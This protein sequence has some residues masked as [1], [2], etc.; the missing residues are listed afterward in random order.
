[1]KN[2]TIFLI[3]ILFN[4]FYYHVFSLDLYVS[5]TGNDTNT[6]AIDNPLQTFDGA[7]KR[8]R[9][10]IGGGISEDI[11]VF[12]REGM[13]YIDTPIEFTEPDSNPTGNRVTYENYGEDDVFIAGGLKIT[14][15]NNYDGMIWSTNVGF[16]D[17]S[18]F[19][20]NRD[21]GIA[22]LNPGSLSLNEMIFKLDCPGKYYY[23]GDT[24]ILYYYPRNN[25]VSNQCIFFPET[26]TIIKLKGSSGSSPVE[27]ISFH[28]LIIVGTR[29][30]S[31]GITSFYDETGLIHMENAENIT[32]DSC[33]LIGAGVSGI[34]VDKYARNIK[35]RNN[36]I[37]DFNFHGVS[38]RGY[39]SGEGPSDA[40][41]NN[42]LS[43]NFIISGAY[44]SSSGS[45]I[46]I[47]QSR[48]NIIEKNRIRYI[49]GNGIIINGPDASYNLVRNN[50]VSRVT[51]VTQGGGIYLFQAGSNNSISNNC[52]HDIYI[53]NSALIP[54][55]IYVGESTSNALIENN[56][57]HTM[58]GSNSKGRA[59]FLSG[60]NC[61]IKN[62]IFSNYGTYGGLGFDASS[63]HARNPEITQNIF[64]KKNG[65]YF[66]VFDEWNNPNFRESNNN[67][68]YHSGS[69]Y[70]VKTPT[71][72][73]DISD[74]RK[75]Y[76]I[77]YDRQSII[78]EDPEFEEPESHYYKVKTGSPVLDL[79]FTNINQD[80]IGIESSFAHRYARDAIEAEDYNTALGIANRVTTIRSSSSGNYTRYGSV[81]FDSSLKKVEIKLSCNASFG[82]GTDREIEIRAQNKYGSLSLCTIPINGTGGITSYIIDK[83]SIETVAGLYDVYLRF[84]GS[85]CPVQVDW[86]RFYAQIPKE[87]DTGINL[88]PHIVFETPRNNQEFPINSNITITAR[89]EDSDGSVVKMWLYANEKLLYE[90][91]DS[92]FSFNWQ[93]VPEGSYLLK[94]VAEDNDSSRDEE[95]V[96]IYVKNILSNPPDVQILEPSE[97]QKF[98]GPCNIDIRVTAEDLSSGI[99]FIEIRANNQHL[100]TVPANS[101]EYTWENVQP[102]DYLITAIA[103]NNAG[104]KQ[105]TAVFIWVTAEN[106]L[107]GHWPMDSVVGG[108]VQD[109][110]GKEHHGTP[111]NAGEIY[112]VKGGGALYF[113]GTAYITTNIPL[114]NVLSQFTMAGWIKPEEG[115]TKVGFFGQAGVVSLG[116]SNDLIL[117]V[118]TIGKGGIEVKYPGQLNTWHHL[119]V[120][121]NQSGMRLYFDGSLI[122]N[123]TQAVSD[124]G[125]SDSPF[126]SGGGIFSPGDTN[127]TGAIDDVRLYSYAIGETELK[128]IASKGEN[129]RPTVEILN[130]PANS[131]YDGPLDISIIVNATDLDGFVESVEVYTQEYHI[132]MAYEPPYEFIWAG[133]TPGTHLLTVKAIDNEYDENSKT[134]MVNVL[135]AQSD[136]L[137]YWDF[138]EASGLI[139]HDSSGN[140][141]NGNINF[142]DWEEEG[143]YGSCLFFD[144]SGNVETEHP[145]ANGLSAFT[146][147][148]WMKATALKPFTGI[149]GQYGA[150]IS[151]FNE[152]GKIAVWTLTNNYTTFAPEDIMTDEWTHI[153]TVATGEQLLIYINGEV[154]AT[155]DARTSDYG[156]SDSNF[157]IGGIKPFNSVNYFFKGY[158]DEVYYYRRA[159]REDEIKRLAMRPLPQSPSLRIISPQ[160]MSQYVTG[161][162]VHIEAKVVK[163]NLSGVYLEIS[164]DGNMIAGLNEQYLLDW[165]FEDTGDHTITITAYST[166]GPWAEGSVVVTILTEEESQDDDDDS[167][168]E[169]ITDETD[170]FDWDE[171]DNDDNNEQYDDDDNGNGNPDDLST[172]FA[173][174]SRDEIYKF[175]EGK[176]EDTHEGETLVE[177]IERIH[178]EKGTTAEKNKGENGKEKKNNRSDSGEVVIGEDGKPV[179]GPTNPPD[180]KGNDKNDK[181]EKGDKAT[182]TASTNTWSW[183]FGNTSQKGGEDTTRPGFL[184]IIILVI[185]II[186]AGIIGVILFKKF[187][188]NK[189]RYYYYE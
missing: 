142:V 103:E 130:P 34:V 67:F 30:K 22:V 46:R 135:E 94:V 60:N 182:N 35:I 172:V 51:P 99:H 136:L 121:G 18:A 132:G 151:S 137:A 76:T 92:Y 87:Q 73:C 50:D 141:N 183:L 114:M 8:V 52:I 56:I 120:I 45:G 78:D 131:S 101:L 160:N 144:G 117:Q 166:D 162:P 169:N 70:Q 10:I 110:S 171:N 176:K 90:T 9:T 145:L 32:V 175:L 39:L 75:I 93:N 156:K 129:L 21:R 57:V 147:A 47:I 27:N 24:G 25:P 165:V 28:D 63:S 157:M 2:K 134:I 16:R 108:V 40:S 84:S 20:E 106:L 152:T 168:D 184:H 100:T 54:A 42:T 43:G 112:G 154:S 105:D 161:T 159:L 88:S 188:N 12:F 155:V 123:S 177:Y 71:L 85:M 97:N 107:I 143:I 41:S 61:T 185:I 138:D 72:I 127:F 11:T 150:F 80:S 128:S 62:N 79:G 59:I 186:A 58:V 4:L 65:R 89:A 69:I 149:M 19:F 37:D 55:G 181:K 68:M 133:V 158:L 139:A 6:G 1:M 111:Y 49:S 81:Y 7:R 95:A 38:L 13:Y 36:R 179:T 29:F 98:Q 146:V 115:G 174:A 104:M 153:A 83:S 31:S 17:T 148:Y 74:W 189:K 167:S 26:E 119:A 86:F 48:N 163:A 113:D 122:G 180:K 5:P 23:D 173:H 15:W 3:V 109:I 82:T 118:Y 33:E 140:N 14:A 91:G 44:K 170:P 64:Y 125:R 102:G 96:Q 77:G 178:K 53:Q 126:N 187:R 116:F 164:I 66:Y 124:Y